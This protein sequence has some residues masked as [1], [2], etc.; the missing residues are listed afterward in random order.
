MAVTTAETAALGQECLK[1]DNFDLLILDL[2]LPDM[3]GRNFFDQ[4]A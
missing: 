4:A 2:V 3:D 1:Q